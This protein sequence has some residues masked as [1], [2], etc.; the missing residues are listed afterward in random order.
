MIE[1]TP[2][3]ISVDETDLLIRLGQRIRTL[4]KEQGL[5]LKELANL[6]DLSLRFVSQ[7]EVGDGNIA[8]TRLAQIANALKVSL[9]ELL[10]NV[11]PA[12]NNLSQLQ[13]DIDTML[14][15]RTESE[16]KQAKRV[17][18]LALGQHQQTTITLLGLRGAGKT[19]IG[20]KLA[21]KLTIP[22]WELD[23]KIEDIAGLSLTEIFSLHGETYYRRLETQA[24]L[25]LFSRQ[26]TA[27]IALPGGIVNNL[28]AFTLTKEKSITVWLKATPTEHMQRVLAQ[29]D[30][31]PIANRPNAMTELQTILTAREPLYKQA[32]LIIDTSTLGINKSI[33]TAISEL[34]NVGWV[35]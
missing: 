27:I 21:S 8:I 34:K 5:T 13:T 7:L 25:E 12:K 6:T 19:T 32:K 35:K 29:G 28:D 31:R 9:S 24:L 11:E 2:E 3:K 20:K 33:E 14:T 1:T 22:F 15:G 30:R 16:L 4:R 10:L 18:A 17:L 26:Q 23:E